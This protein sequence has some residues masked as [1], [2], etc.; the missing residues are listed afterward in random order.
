MRQSPDPS[1]TSSQ[2][3]DLPSP[4]GEHR[5]H[6]G[7]ESSPAVH[8]NA[9]VSRPVHTEA[10]GLMASP[11]EV[12]IGFSFISLRRLPMLIPELGN[13][14]ASFYRPAALWAK[15]C[16]FRELKTTIQTACCP[17]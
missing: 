13:S 8:K 10:F 12:C 14:E 15:I 11:A 3:R 1:Q 5:L 16:G 17:I 2:D 9:D 4:Q 7:R 6:E